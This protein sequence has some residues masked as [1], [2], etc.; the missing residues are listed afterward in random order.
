[1][2]QQSAYD[3]NAELL[4]LNLPRQFTTNIKAQS[5]PITA[6]RNAS[7]SNEPMTTGMILASRPIYDLCAVSAGHITPFWQQAIASLA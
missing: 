6:S 2:Q 7:A 3:G 1:M 4:G 5:T